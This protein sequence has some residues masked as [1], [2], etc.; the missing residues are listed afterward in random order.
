MPTQQ[1]MCLHFLV[2]YWCSLKWVNEV[3]LYLWSSWKLAEAR[4]EWRGV[5]HQQQPLV[6]KMVFAVEGDALSWSSRWWKWLWRYLLENLRLLC[7]LWGR[8]CTAY[9]KICGFQAK[10]VVVRTFILQCFATAGLLYWYMCGFTMY[11]IWIY[12]GFFIFRAYNPY[13]GLRNL[14]FSWFRGPRVRSI[15][16]VFRLDPLPKVLYKMPAIWLYK[17]KGGEVISKRLSARFF[18]WRPHFSKGGPT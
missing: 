13:I 4:D 14:H 8:W 10:I 6:Q 3:K 7:S 11:I 12:H 18:F 17:M 2:C 5:Y 15:F 1:G 16:D 9:L